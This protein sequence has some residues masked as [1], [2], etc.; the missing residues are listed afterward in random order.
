MRLTDFCF[1]AILYKLISQ[2]VKLQI[3]IIGLPGHIVIGVPSLNRYVDVFR[4]GRRLLTT[5]DCERIVNSYGHPLIPEYMCPLAPAQ[6][7]RRILNNCGNCLAQ[8]FPP[9]ASKR[10]AIEAMRAVLINPTDDQVEDC[11][12]WFSQ[13]LWGSHSSAI[14]QEMSSW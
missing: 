13:I 2:R 12:R 5:L 3:D 4:K 8:T 14:L 7:F 10:M 11:R 1:P 6:V 9:N